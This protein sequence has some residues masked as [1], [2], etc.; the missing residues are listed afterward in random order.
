MRLTLTAPSGQTHV[1]STGSPPSCGDRE[2]VR[3]VLRRSWTFFPLARLCNV[4]TTHTAC[5][6]PQT[7]QQ[8]QLK[9]ML[10]EYMPPLPLPLPPPYHSARASSPAAAQ[11]RHATGPRMHQRQ[12]RVL[13]PRSQSG[14]LTVPVVV[15]TA[16]TA[17]WRTVPSS[18]DRLAPA[19]SKYAAIL[20][21]SEGARM[22]PGSSSS[23]ISSEAEA[24]ADVSPQPH[25]ERPKS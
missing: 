16:R 8:R 21:A 23:E 24:S 6:I 12:T 9:G 13:Y 15:K 19:G 2:E 10:E 3:L 11:A 20:D 17:Q 22:V 7:A 5:F 14:G 4:E 1:L 18:R 25:L